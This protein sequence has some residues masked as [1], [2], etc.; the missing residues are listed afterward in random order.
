MSAQ[1][2]KSG[3]NERPRAL[4]SV[5]ALPPEPTLY[6]KEIRAELAALTGEPTRTHAS[7]ARAPHYPLAP[8]NISDSGSGESWFDP[9]R[10]N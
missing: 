6:G 10:G 1:V 7:P 2:R 4:V 5:R 8:A 9:R 3:Q